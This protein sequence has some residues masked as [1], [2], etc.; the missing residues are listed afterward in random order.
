MH[1]TPTPGWANENIAEL[2]ADLARLEAEDQDVDVGGCG[3][4]VLEHPREELCAVDQQVPARR[5][6]GRSRA[7]AGAAR[8][9]KATPTRPAG[10]RFLAHEADRLTAP[11]SATAPNEHQ[12]AAADRADEDE[13]D[14]CRTKVV[15]KPSYGPATLTPIGEGQP[16]GHDRGF[17]AAAPATMQQQRAQQRKRFRRRP[18]RVAG[19]RSSRSAFIVLVLFVVFGLIL[20]RYVDYLE[21]AEALSALTLEQMVVMTVLGATAWFVHGQLSM[22]LI[23]S[24]RRSAGTRRT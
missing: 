24:C 9:G 21:V 1:R 2:V 19:P 13:E 17:E 6:C 14:A 5:S 23:P 16:R 15:A 18:C 10:G 4:D 7:I 3:L 22:L 11:A 20:P 8:P 12:A